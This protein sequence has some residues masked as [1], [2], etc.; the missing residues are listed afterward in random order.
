[1]YNAPNVTVDTCTS[2]AVPKLAMAYSNDC[3]S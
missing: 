2:V 1:M 3:S